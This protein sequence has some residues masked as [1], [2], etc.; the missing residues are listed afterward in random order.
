MKG[1]A[2]EFERPS[3]NGFGAVTLHQG[4]IVDLPNGEWWGFSMMDVKSAGRLTF[5][6]PVTWKD[7]WPYFGLGRKPRTLTH[8]P[9]SNRIHGT[10]IAPLTTYQRE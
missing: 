4:G 7:G 8:A 5:L 3:E 9:G 2:M 6:S 1:E 10:D